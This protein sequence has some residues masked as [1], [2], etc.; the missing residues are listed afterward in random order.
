MNTPPCIQT[1]PTHATERH[2]SRAPHRYLSADRAGTKRPEPSVGG[3]EWTA[4][5]MRDLWTPLG[6]LRSGRR[7]CRCRLGLRGM[8]RIA[9]LRLVRVDDELNKVAVGIP[10]VDAHPVRAPTLASTASRN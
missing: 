3:Q 7:A 10:C 4:H 5:E 8:G 1:P 2:P 9:P 6:H